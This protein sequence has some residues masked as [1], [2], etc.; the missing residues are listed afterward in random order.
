V[1]MKPSELVPQTADLIA[2]MVASAFDETEVAAVTGG[3]E[4]ARGFS[5][6]PFDHL[7]FTGSAG[8]ARV[9]MAT[10]A[11]NLVPV[12]LELGGKSPAIVASGA[13]V[14][15]AAS[16]IVFGKFANAGQV[17]MAPDFVLVHRVQKDAFAAAVRVEIKKQYPQGTASP[18]F[19]RVHLPKQR[20]RLA[21]LVA[22]AKA[23]GASVEALSGDGIEA[24][25]DCEIFPPVLVIDPPLDSELMRDEVF[26]PVLAI[27]AYDTLEEAV[28]LVNRLSR[29]LALYFIGGSRAQKDY[30]LLNTY[31]GGVTFDDVMLHPFMQDLP[32]GG[33]GE[34]GM[35]RYL[36]YDG[37]KA[38]S[39]QR[40]VVQRPWIDVTRFIAP[41][42]TPAIVRMMRRAIRF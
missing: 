25:A 15:Y 9:V 38:L 37:F 34:S 24:L 6:L 20:E 13:D 31:S 10:A 4:V 5:A 36:S 27:F 33:V 39:N 7:V 8:T 22:E 2:E 32:F 1:L 3:L 28:A 19:T 26:G 29:P 17:C 11:Q 42:F 21:R 14:A 40:G 12:T 23:G 18:D 41:P 35:G 16:K 30:L